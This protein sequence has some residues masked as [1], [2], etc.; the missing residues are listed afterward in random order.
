MITKI[1]SSVRTHRLSINAARRLFDREARRHLRMSGKEFLRRWEAGKF[2][3]QAD[4]SAVRR[5]AMLLP[6]G[7]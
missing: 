1:K 4:T 7:R 2:N 3:G 6:F 5:V